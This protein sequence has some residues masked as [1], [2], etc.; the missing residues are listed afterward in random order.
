MVY[1]ICENVPFSEESQPQM[2]R[3]SSIDWRA[4]YK[5]TLFSLAFRMGL[6]LS[7]YLTCLNMCLGKN[8][9]SHAFLWNVLENI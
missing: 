7:V 5:G 3:I 6:Q 4:F 9:A 2:S 1:R 8:T